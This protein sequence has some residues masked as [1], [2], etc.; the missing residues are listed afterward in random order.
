[1]YCQ[2]S[3]KKNFKGNITFLYNFLKANIIRDTAVSISTGL[4]KIE[5]LLADRGEILDEVR[6]GT[7]RGQIFWLGWILYLSEMWL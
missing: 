2:V 3:K 1:M 4:E 5:A 6:Y 7:S